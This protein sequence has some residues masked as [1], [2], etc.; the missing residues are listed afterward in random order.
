MKKMKS[1]PTR[2]CN[3]SNNNP[4]WLYLTPQSSRKSTNIQYMTSVHTWSSAMTII[5]K[6]SSTVLSATTTK[7]STNGQTSSVFRSGKMV[8]ALLK[9]CNW[10]RIISIE[11]WNKSGKISLKCNPNKEFSTSTMKSFIPCCSTNCPIIFI[12]LQSILRIN[13]I[14]WES[15]EVLLLLT[16]F[17]IL[18]FKT[19]IWFN[20]I[21]L[22]LFRG[23]FNKSCKCQ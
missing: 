8:W 23:K 19:Y 5:K 7:I 16:Q 9:S 15:G 4:S 17:V 6:Y 12:P 13:R 20:R 22:S 3:K 14:L 10:F 18:F 1:S 11:I 2:Q 21:H